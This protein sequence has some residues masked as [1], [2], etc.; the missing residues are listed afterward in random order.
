MFD[1]KERTLESKR[2]RQD[3]IVK[4][5]AV[6]KAEV[7]TLESLQEELSEIRSC[8]SKQIIEEKQVAK[9]KP[10]RKKPKGSNVKHPRTDAGVKR[11]KPQN[12]PHTPGSKR[13]RCRRD[14]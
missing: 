5:Q 13:Q 11:H 2:I 9:S 12:P 8:I 3:K 1:L 6:A 4:A 14:I 7:V 10:R